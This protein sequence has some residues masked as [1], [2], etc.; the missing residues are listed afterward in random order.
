MTYCYPE[1]QHELGSI[2]YVLGG[3]T[4]IESPSDV[5]P[6]KIRTCTSKAPLVKVKVRVFINFLSMFVG[7]LVHFLP[8]PI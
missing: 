4:N 6:H 7:Q 1:T 3:L 5:K 2:Y 8:F